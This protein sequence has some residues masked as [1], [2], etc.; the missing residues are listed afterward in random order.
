MNIK[1]FFKWV[2]ILLFFLILKSKIKLL[3]FNPFGVVTDSLL[4]SW[5][6]LNEDNQKL[7]AEMRLVESE[8]G[9]HVNTY[10]IYS[11][12]RETMNIATASDAAEAIEQ[13]ASLLKSTESK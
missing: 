5:D 10:D 9:V 11:R 4:F 1:F 13:L 8:L 2:C 12:P 6:E 3:D 7:D